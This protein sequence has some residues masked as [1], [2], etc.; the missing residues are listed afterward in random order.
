MHTETV[1][2][3]YGSIGIFFHTDCTLL[4]SIGDAIWPFY[5]FSHLNIYIITKPRNKCSISK[6][7]Y[8]LEFIK[9]K[10]SIAVEAVTNLFSK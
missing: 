2:T 7:F 10:D 6:H 5:F 1:D 8:G 3:V 9:S 4:G